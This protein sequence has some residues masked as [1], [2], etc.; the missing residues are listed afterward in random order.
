MVEPKRQ[1][2]SAPVVS[3]RLSYPVA[4]SSV[5]VPK[6]EAEAPGWE[7]GISGES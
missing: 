5:I 7:Q 4:T 1:S 6:E 3:Q 2:L